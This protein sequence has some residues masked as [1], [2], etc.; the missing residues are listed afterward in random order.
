[1]ARD[2]EATKRRIFEAAT[3][4]FAA[5]GFAGARID[6]IAETAGA[7]KQLIYA[8][9]GSKQQLFDAVITETVT[10]FLE[11]VPFDAEELPEF[12]VGAYDFFTANPEIVRLGSWHTL[13]LEVSEYHVEVIERAVG[14]HTRAV[15][16]AQTEG[17]VDATLGAQELF[18][19][20]V[21]IASAWAVATPE[22]AHL[23]RD[24]PRVRSRRRAAVREAVKRLVEP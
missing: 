22:I 14:E 8:Y 21:S 6:R 18:A 16:R 20:I 23:S 12:A 19:L 15:K 1:M 3:A 24:D 4:E 10:R 9:F 11:E 7:N 2:A 17:L 5:R 13:E